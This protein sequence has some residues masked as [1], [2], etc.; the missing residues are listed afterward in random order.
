M[1]LSAGSVLVVAQSSSEFPE[2]LMN[3]PVI[4]HPIYSIDRAAVVTTVVFLCL[5]SQKIG[6][7]HCEILVC[8]CI[9]GVTVTLAGMFAVLYLMKGQ[10]HQKAVNKILFN[11]RIKFGHE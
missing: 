10:F 2:G 9:Y 8:S 6:Y 3:N 5:D 7:Q 11:V 1:L 4:K